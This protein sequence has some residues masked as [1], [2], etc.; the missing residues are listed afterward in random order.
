MSSVKVGLFILIVIPVTFALGVIVGNEYN[1]D[2][3]DMETV[4]KVAQKVYALGQQEG[5]VEGWNACVT[6]VKE[7][8]A[9]QQK[10]ENGAVPQRHDIERPLNTSS[11][12]SKIV[13]CEGVGNET[14]EEVRRWEQ[15]AK[16]DRNKWRPPFNT[17]AE[18]KEY[19]DWYKAHPNNS[20]PFESYRRY[21]ERKEDWADYDHGVYK[22]RQG[23]IPKTQEEIQKE[24]DAN[25][26]R[27]KESEK[28]KPC[29]T[30]IGSFKNTPF[31]DGFYYIEMFGPFKTKEE[32]S[33]GR[34]AYWDIGNILKPQ[35]G[36][37]SV[38]AG[39]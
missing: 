1:A 26:Y 37:R 16:A 8:E 35:F 3:M 27:V 39:N 33:K 31:A 12:E 14:D 10:K 4:Q 22:Y 9:E 7:Y 25:P 2:K 29:T 30:A 19:T 34:G 21:L 17:D 38:P 32:A 23:R 13:L 5:Y 36:L 24:I 28:V 20:T 11:A 6:K 18:V 15:E